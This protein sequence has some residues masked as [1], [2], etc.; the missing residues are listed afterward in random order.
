VFSAKDIRGNH[1]NL[2]E[3]IL[4]EETPNAL[5]ID[6]VP[7]Q[8]V[9]NLLV[10]DW[11]MAINLCTRVGR[12]GYRILYVYSFHTLHSEEYVF[13]FIK[14]KGVGILSMSIYS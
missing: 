7:L 8:P 10:S 5:M 14:F 9:Q 1:A 4:L 6:Y 3:A 13:V 2:Y 12:P 11:K